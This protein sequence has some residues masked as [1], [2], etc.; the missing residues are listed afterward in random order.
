MANDSKFAL[1]LLAG[2]GVIALLYYANQQ[3]D[4]VLPDPE[5][6][7]EA[8]VMGLGVQGTFKVAAGSPLDTEHIHHG[9]FPGYDPDPSAQPVVEPRVRYPALPGGNISSVLHNG[10]SQVSNKPPAGGG[11]FNNPPEAAVI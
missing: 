2:A 5:I 7:T 9:W 11:W 6:Q 10:W 3:T 1:C 4:N 8:Q